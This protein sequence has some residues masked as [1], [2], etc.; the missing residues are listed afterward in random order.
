[1]LADGSPRLPSRQA[2]VR[3]AKI[4][5]SLVAVISISDWGQGMGIARRSFLQG[6]S[7]L[8]AILA[9]SGLG[10]S[11]RAAAAPEGWPGSRKLALLIGLNR[12]PSGA[13]LRG[14]LTD[15]SCQYDLLVSRFGFMPEDIVTLTDG[16]AT[17]EA[18][19]T[20]FIDRLIARAT[21]NDRVLVHFSGYGRRVRAGE[22][23]QES[24][25]V[26]PNSR[27]NGDRDVLLSTLQLL[28]RSLATPHVALVLDTSFGNG[29]RVLFGNL[30]S[31]TFPNSQI[32]AVGAAELAFQENFRRDRQA[33]ESVSEGQQGPFWLRASASGQ[34]A[35]EG[36]WGGF[37]S[38]L[39]TYA[40][41]QALW[42]A[43]PPRQIWFD[44][45]LASQQTSAWTGGWQQPQF[46]SQA[47]DTERAPSEPPSYGGS[48]LAAPAVG[49]ITA[50]ERDSSISMRLTGLPL[51]VL[52]GYALNSCLMA[53]AED[54]ADPSRLQIYAREGLNVRAKLVA[55]SL[56]S[57]GQTVREA[58]RVLPYNPGLTVAL[59]ASFDRIERVDTT[60]AFA[61]LVNIGIL[62]SA[63]DGVADCVFGRAPNG[64]YSL[65]W[66]NGTA[67]PATIGPNNEAI[68]SAVGRLAGYFNTLLAAK[69][70]RMLANASS[71]ELRVKAGLEMSYP[72]AMLLQQQGTT[73]GALEG[74]EGLSGASLARAKA[75]GEIHYCLENQGDRPLYFVVLGLDAAG[76]AVAFYLPSP[77]VPCIAP[78]STRIV[79]KPAAA[80]DWI[81]AGPAG[82]AEIY[83]FLSVAP[84]Q[85]TWGAIANAASTRGEGERVVTVTAPLAIAQA[86]QEDLRAA[87]AVS[88]ELFGYDPAVFAIDLAN[89]AALDFVYQVEVA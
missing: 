6:V 74:R 56:P 88:G 69:L 60:S 63:G 5:G 49:Y 16:A 51:A 50:V 28:A 11:S 18:I 76:N 54:G 40:L 72:Q 17:R 1:M 36:D 83:I 77:T 2:I 86:L 81:V 42:Q 67:I 14:S 25:L 58:T 27:D 64:G 47:N 33:P 70:W 15:V 45:A 39:F 3:L 26:T 66:P 30:R 52:R 79:P 22:T 35:V 7:Q 23:E 53:N 80:Y 43:A 71:T 38:G 61:N 85:G 24:L 46:G 75:G 78:N 8:L 13:F 37:Q 73:G 21:P 20:A 48:L 32:E 12:Y 59:D 65:Q 41:T 82:I 31:R 29:D 44:L 34:P 55:G 4:L 89:W 9:V 87:S 68:K 57:P 62:S 10:R 19:E 84:L